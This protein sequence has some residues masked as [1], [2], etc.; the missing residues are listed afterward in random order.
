VVG[1]GG[2]EFERQHI[3]ETVALVESLAM[4]AGSLVSLVDADELDTR[5]A[6]D[7]PF[8]PLDAS[9]MSGQREE[10]K[11]RLSAALMPRKVK[12]ATY[13]TDKRWK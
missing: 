9:Q 13:S 11:G 7:R 5:A 3:D 1:A 4:P 12:V 10:L 2:V 6:T 8:S